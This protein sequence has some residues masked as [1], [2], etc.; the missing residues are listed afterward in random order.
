MS[1]VR[2]WIH[3]VFAT[4]NRFPFLP[5]KVRSIV[6]RHMME[7]P[8]LKKMKVAIIN[9]YSEYAH[10]LLS[11]NRDMTISTA[12]QL[13]KGESHRWINKNKL[14][15]EKCMWQDDY[16]AVSLSESHSNGSSTI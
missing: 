5:E 6:F 1:W 9:A 2:A 10:S 11:I 13:I 14:V 12:N 16:W 7:N 3:I 15:D 4:K 8:E